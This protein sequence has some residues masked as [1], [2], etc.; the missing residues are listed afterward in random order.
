MKSVVDIIKD[1][2]EESHVPMVQE[3]FGDAGLNILYK[4][5]DTVKELYK[6]VE[7]ERISGQVII[8]QRIQ[9]N[10]NPAIAP[11]GV[12]AD[13]ACYATQ[14]VRDLCF[15]VST[16]GRPY[17]YTLGSITKEELAETSVVYY[18]NCAHEEILA[19][20]QCKPVLRLD[21][22]ALSKF[23]V[24]TLSTLREALQRYARDNVRE[25]TCY[26]FRNVWYDENRLFFSAG[27][28]SVMRNS[29]NQYLC[30]RLGGDHD[31]WPEQ[32]V[33]EQ[34][35]VDIRVQTRFNNNRLMLIEIK[36]LGDSAD[37]TGHVTARHRDSRAQRGAEQL[38]G[39]LDEQRRTAPSHVSQGYYVIIDG[40]RRNLPMQAAHGITIN[41]TDGLYYES[42]EV[43]FNPA[44]HL[45]RT[46]FDAPYR[47]FAKPVC[48]D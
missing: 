4:V 17:I 15:E 36:W 14:N 28:E 47:M 18:Y 41:H 42:Q 26:I 29:L 5:I 30:N 19:G 45:S 12:V 6:Y 13:F 25:S 23:S 43:N 44:A 34:N 11:V 16:D 40:R 24:P 39:Y 10:G 1:V 46:D 27:P 33:N 37:N 21:S 48:C 9:T 3:V 38:A 35:P 7:P 2:C 22:T 20:S 32:N 31:I 8:F